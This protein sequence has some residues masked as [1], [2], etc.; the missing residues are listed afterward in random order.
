MSETVGTFGLGWDQVLREKK[1]CWLPG[2]RLP[3]VCS[4]YSENDN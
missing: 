3:D 4:G 2:G 1:Q